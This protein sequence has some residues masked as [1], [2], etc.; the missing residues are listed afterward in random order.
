MIDKILK[1]YRQIVGAPT[2][3]IRLAC[4]AN[5]L[6]AINIGRIAEPHHLTICDRKGV[7]SFNEFRGRLF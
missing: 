1:R 5:K 6:A 3:L 4:E 2:G 7:E